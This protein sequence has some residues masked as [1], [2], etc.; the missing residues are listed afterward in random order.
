MVIHS[1]PGS[2]RSTR[3]TQEHLRLSTGSQAS[4]TMLQPS[5]VL[6]GALKLVL[7]S[8]EK[9]GEGEIQW[10]LVL[11]VKKQGFWPRNGLR[12][13]VQCKGRAFSASRGM[14]TPYLRSPDSRVREGAETPS[15]D[16]HCVQEQDT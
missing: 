6:K 5:R 3:E 10:I 16:S 8:T 14:D 1:W 12:F 11:Q 9:V 2:R 7:K 13:T 4:P 15:Q